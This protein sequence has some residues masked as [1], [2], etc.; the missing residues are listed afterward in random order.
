MSKRRILLDTRQVIAVD[1]TVVHRF[2]PAKRF[3]QPVLVGDK[4]WEQQGVDYGTII[5]DDGRYRFWYSTSPDVPTRGNT[6]WVAYAESTDGIHWEKPDL[7]VMPYKEYKRTNLMTLILHEPSVIKD[8]REPDPAKRYK[9]AGFVGVE[10]V[11]HEQGIR[12]PGDGYYLSYSPD[13]IHWS[14]YPQDKP[15]GTNHD[16]GSFLWDDSHG[17][18]IA[19]VKL[20]QRYDL[21]DRR[22]IAIMTSED[23]V[24][25]RQPR[26]ALVADALDDRMARERGAHHAE[27]YGMGWMPYEDMYVGFLWLFWVTE[28][29]MPDPRRRTG[30]WG[31]LEV[32]L[33]WSYDGF[34]WFRTPDRQA[35]IP[36]GQIGEFDSRNMQTLSRAIAV[37][38]EVRIYYAGGARDHAYFSN[39]LTAR[40]SF[41]Y[42]TDIDL[43][44]VGNEVVFSFASIK[45]DRY[46]SLSTGTQGSFTVHHGV[47][48]GRRLLV[49]AR[50]PLGSV[51]AQLLDADLAPIP[52]FGIEECQGF[53]GDS[54]RDEV[55]WTGRSID[56]LAK[57]KEIHIRF[58]LDYADI[59]AYELTA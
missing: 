56:S 22:S 47:P 19:N 27:L 1:P 59:F 50:A 18:F 40:S 51:K 4:P 9:A 5:V 44:K 24:H 45:Q 14:P 2:W 6:Y 57:D 25:W 35:F 30:W 13:G 28:P 26:T 20:Q 38:D 58:V 21:I 36:L 43:R 7:D 17:R 32:Q 55:T 3:G 11:L 41:D 34:Y 53:T 37:G 23:F 29:L 31:S 42:R 48:D 16:V 12:Y 39:P 54:L 33:I 10:Q 52:G 49:N 8:S 15:V 46:A